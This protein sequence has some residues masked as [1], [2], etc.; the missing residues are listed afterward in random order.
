MR[1]Q[2]NEE[3]NAESGF[4]GLLGIVSAF[5]DTTFAGIAEPGSRA[6]I[7]RRLICGSRNARGGRVEVG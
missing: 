5:K 4:S 3:M 6:Q 7:A 2:A 1:K